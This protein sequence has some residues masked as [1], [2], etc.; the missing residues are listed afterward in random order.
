[1]SNEIKSIN[2][3]PVGDDGM[4]HLTSAQLKALGIA[5]KK[6]KKPHGMT[7]DGVKNAAGKLDQYVNEAVAVYNKIMRLADGKISR[8]GQDWPIDVTD[9]QRDWAEDK[10]AS[11]HATTFDA[12]K[13]GIRPK[14]ILDAC[15]VE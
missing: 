5:S 6:V 2:D 8:D 4:R 7:K 3:V 12:L 1:M 11:M 10:L 13:A 9:T 14:A 15:P